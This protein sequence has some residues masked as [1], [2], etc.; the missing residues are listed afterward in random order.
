MATLLKEAMDRRGLTQK[1]LNRLRGISY[2]FARKH[3]VGECPI[4]A[5]TA[6]L[7]EEQLGIPRYELRPDLW[8]PAMFN[9][10]WMDESFTKKEDN[11]EGQ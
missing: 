3:Y 4:S 7:Y 8:T 1:D 9:Y 10:L 6:L 2:S 5:K 11:H